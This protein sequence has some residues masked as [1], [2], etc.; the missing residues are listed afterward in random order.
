MRRSLIALFVV[1]L[2]S[3]PGFVFLAGNQSPEPIEMGHFVANYFYLAAPQIIVAALA[4]PF[5]PVRTHLLISLVLLN[6]ALSAFA[7]WIHIA[8]PS[9]ESGLAWVLYFPV[10]AAVLLLVALAAIFE[11]HKAKAPPP[12]R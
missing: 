8:V 10:S 11:N 4:I 1:A 5:T 9:R 7:L 6:V 3:F 2:L 12:P